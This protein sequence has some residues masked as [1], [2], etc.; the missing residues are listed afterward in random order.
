MANLVENTEGTKEVSRTVTED[1]AEVHVE[2][3]KNLGN[4]ENIKYRVGLGSSRRDNETISDTAD[5]VAREAEQ[6]LLE[7]I[8][9]LSKEL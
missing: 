6:V 4:F 8:Q 3:T 2:Y 5:R 1:W 9:Q 7:K